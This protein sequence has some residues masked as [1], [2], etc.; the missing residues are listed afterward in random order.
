MKDLLSKDWKM[1]VRQ[2]TVLPSPISK[3]TN[4]EAL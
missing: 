4:F 2:I 3:G 1:P